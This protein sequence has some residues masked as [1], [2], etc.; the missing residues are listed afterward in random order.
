MFKDT[1]NEVKESIKTMMTKDGI[2][3]QELETL[4]KLNSQ[5]D[6]LAKQHQELD[7]S[8]SKMKDKYIEA[9]TGFGTTKKP[10]EVDGGQPRTFEQIAQDVLAKSN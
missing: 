5:V 6:D 2:T 4:T 1:L 3:D 8:H 9:I 7:E 10:D